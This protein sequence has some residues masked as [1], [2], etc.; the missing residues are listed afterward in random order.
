MNAFVDISQTILETERLLLRPWRQEDLQ[1]FYDYASV[2]GVGQMA[3]WEP[4]KSL[5][6]SQKILDL[7]INEKKTFAL[8]DKQTGR[9][10]GSLGLESA[11]RAECG[12]SPDILAQK[13]GREI[14]YVLRREDWGRG[15]MPEAVRRVIRHCFDD[16]HMD[17]LLCGHFNEN[18]QSRRVI[19]KCGFS[20]WKDIV[21][22]GAR[23]AMRTGEARPGKMY[24]LLRE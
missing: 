2:D 16:L 24:I 13:Q 12:E 3:G 7:F 20:Y 22:P 11:E 4:H 19:E 18:R 5:E 6:M 10:I 14:G 1:D 8:V 9:V 17:F 21:F 15:L 23:G